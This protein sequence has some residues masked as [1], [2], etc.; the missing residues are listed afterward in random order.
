MA[1]R[2]AETEAFAAFLAEHEGKSLLRFLTCGSV[3]D[4]KST[5]IGRLLYDTKRLFEDQLADAQIRFE[6]ASAPPAATSISPCSSTA[7]SPSASRASPSTSPTA[8]SPP[9]GAASSSPTRPATSSTPATWRP[10]RRPP[11]SPSCWS[12]RATASSPRPGGT[13]IIVS[14]LGIRHVVL[15]VNKIDLVGF[16]G[17]RFLDIVARLRRVRRALRLRRRSSPIP[18]SARFGDNV[19]ERSAHTPWYRRADAARAPRDGRRSRTATAAEPFRFPVQWVNRPDAELPR[20]CRHGR[21][22]QR[23]G[24]ATRWSSR[25]PAR[26]RGSRASSPWT[27]TSPSADAGD[28]VTLTLDSEIDVE[29]RRRARRRR[30]S[31]RRSP[32]RSPPISSG[33]AR[34]RCC[35][36]RPYLLKAGDAHGRRR[37]QRPQAP[38]STSRRFK[39]LAAKTLELNEIG[40]CNLSLAEPIAFDL[41]DDNRDHRLLH[42]DRPLHQRDRRRRHDPLRPAARDQHPLAGARRRTSRPAPSSRASGRASCGSPA[43]P[44]PASRPSPTS[45]RRSSTCMGRHTY[46]LDG[47]NVRHGL[48][49]DL[50]F[51]DADRVEN[52]RRVAEVAKLFVDAGLIV[53]VS[54]ISPF[55]SERDMARE[56]VGEGEFV[57]VFVDTPLVGRR[58]ARP[59]GPLHARRAPARS[60]T[61][62]ASTRPT[63][64][65]SSPTSA[66]TPPTPTPTSSPSGWW[67]ACAA[68][69]ICA[70]RRVGKGAPAPCP[71]RLDP[72]AGRTR[73][74]GARRAFAHPTGRAGRVLID[75][76]SAAV[77]SPGMP[78]SMRS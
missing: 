28:A 11:I 42:P 35:P 71:L 41:Y 4:G 63:R 3:D 47:D 34:S 51:T 53:L 23:R 78:G 32:T 16:D 36:G 15:A 9:T 18:I 75:W 66:S 6:A 44:A 70:A 7:S 57:E 40:L 62:P 20:L 72:D 21:R 56:L 2:L 19:I 37:G 5:L 61:S 58:G 50:G 73:G 76:M 60:R 24:R 67:T 69:A 39:P 59:E 38:A 29:P 74:H 49:R 25:A 8:I 52:I 64:R 13:P 46:L 12:T 27:A 55:R 43:C 45:S 48:N 22:R 31:G 77:P 17:E 10:A 54:F 1:H 65:R 14:L 30:S 26:R 68:A 33:W